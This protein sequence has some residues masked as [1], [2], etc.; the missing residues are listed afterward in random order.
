ME[1]ATDPKHLATITTLN[2]RGSRALSLQ[3]TL[4]SNVFLVIVP[5]ALGFVGSLAP[6]FIAVNVWGSL[7]VR[8]FLIVLGTSV[9]VTVCSIAIWATRFPE[10]PMN[11]WLDQRLRNRCRK[12]FQS[13]PDHSMKFWID[14]APMC[15]YVRREAMQATLFPKLETAS[16]I[17]L[18][19]IHADGI[20]MEGDRARYSFPAASILGTTIETI[21]PAGCFHKLHYVHVFVRTEQGT[22]EFP[23]SLRDCGWGRLSAKKR[24]V[25]AEQLAER[26]NQIATGS[27]YELSD[28]DYAR[29]AQTSPTNSINPYAVAAS[30]SPARP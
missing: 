1:H 10:W 6:L 15:E 22:D 21:R 3:F 28:P 20:T 17:A 12:R 18:I 4:I 25:D 14:S 11:Q 27:E 9:G 19:R 29:R 13:S 23:I 7:S 24:R 26:I 8:S 5:T 2:E 16:D 30:L